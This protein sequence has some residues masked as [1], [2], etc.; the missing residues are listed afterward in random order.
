MSKNNIKI[1]T[2]ISVSPEMK[3]LRLY[4]I[5]L[6]ALTGVIGPYD[7][8]CVNEADDSNENKTVENLKQSENKTRTSA[9]RSCTA[10]PTCLN[11]QNH[12][13]HKT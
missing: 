8:K 13:L 12:L 10:S 4:R 1:T 9:S 6:N 11:A 3:P 2:L 7:R 5:P